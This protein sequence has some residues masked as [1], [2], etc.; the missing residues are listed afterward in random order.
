METAAL[1]LAI[2]LFIAGLVGTVLPVL[3]GA[4]LVYGGM[5]LYGFMTGFAVLDAAFFVLQALA[6]AVIF[7]IDFLA[8]AAGTKRFG[9]SR[10][11]AWGAVLGT[12]LGIILMGPLGIVIGPFLGATAAELLRGTELNQAF[13][14]GFGTLVG[15]LGGTILKLGAEMLMIVYFFMRVF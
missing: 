6:L 3:P 2:I 9:G 12:I 14:A 5:L 8:S 4:I 7:L 11:A 1:V 13:R 15:I 10:Q